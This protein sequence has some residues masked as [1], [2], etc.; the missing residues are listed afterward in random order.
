[1]NELIEN[2]SSM[3]WDSL[4]QQPSISTLSQPQSPPTYAS[5]QLGMEQFNPLLGNPMASDESNSAALFQSYYLH[6]QDDKFFSYPSE[7]TLPPTA[8]NYYQQRPQSSIQIQNPTISPGQLITQ[9]PHTPHMSLPLQ[10]EQKITMNS[11]DK[12]SLQFVPSQ[13]L[14]N[15]PKNNK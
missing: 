3:S 13:V 5:F 2:T 15:I 10:S 12:A 1:M 7:S 8:D 11:I 14:R 4:T 9:T 6:P